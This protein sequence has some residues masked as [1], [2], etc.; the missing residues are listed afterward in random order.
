MLTPELAILLDAFE[1]F[2][3]AKFN[4]FNADAKVTTNDCHLVGSHAFFA[5]HRCCHCFSKSCLRMLKC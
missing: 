3:C 2:V 5:G 4:D 1:P